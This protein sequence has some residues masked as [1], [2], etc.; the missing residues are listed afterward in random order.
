MKQW[1]NFL[2][3]NILNEFLGFLLYLERQTELDQ[4][5]FEEMG[6]DQFCRKSSRLITIKWLKKQAKGFQKADIEQT[7]WGKKQIWH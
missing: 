4:G 3:L 7:V 1:A 6:P 2:A 5:S